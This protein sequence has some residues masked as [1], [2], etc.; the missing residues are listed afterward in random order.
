MRYES[1]FKKRRSAE[2][3]KRGV[4]VSADRA[5]RGHWD[6]ERPDRD[7]SV[8]ATGL[9]PATGTGSSAHLPTDVRARDSIS[10]R[11]GVG[12][13]K[14]RRNSA[15]GGTVGARPEG[16]LQICDSVHLVAELALDHR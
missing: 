16:V 8:R 12:R 2:F 6:A 9:E 3:Y 10:A 4:E 15:G 7:G 5:K 11:G 13:R 1:D 14:S